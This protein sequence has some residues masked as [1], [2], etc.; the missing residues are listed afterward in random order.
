MLMID[1]RK[2]IGYPVQCGELLPATKEMYSIFPR[3]TELEELFEIDSSVV[4]GESE[5]IKII[6]PGGR[7]YSI[8][9]LSR[10]LDR[11]SFDKHLVKMAE[12]AGARLMSG[13]MLRSIGEDATVETTAGRI[14]AKVIVGADGPNSRTAREAGLER[15]SASYPAITCRTETTFGNEVRMYFGRDAPGGY[16]W[17]IPKHS[18]A[19]MGVGFSCD[20][21]SDRP[22]ELLARFASRLGVT[23]REQTLGFVPMAGPSKRTVAGNVLLVG[24][25][26]GHTMASNGGGI[27]TAMIAGREA[28]R[29]IRRHLTDGA[30]LNSYETAWR[31]S[32]EGPL[33]RSFKTVRLAGF[34]FR[35]DAL[36]GLAMAIL[37]RRGLERAIR[38]KRLFL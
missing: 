14:K 32:M 35:N 29:V 21:R 28:G 4:A 9:F 20:A 33:T 2:E 30:S 16:A 12:E 34:A 22:T 31:A 38:C 13:V 3:G 10:T 6:S 23:I 18:G 27:P 15:P 24:D 37:G 1:R 8:P 19:N 11:R 25:A 36:L 26:A 5:T 7:A 17:V